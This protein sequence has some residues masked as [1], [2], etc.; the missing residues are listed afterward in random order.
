MSEYTEVERP[1]LQQLVELGWTV[2]DQGTGVPQDAAPSLRGNFR[3]WLLPEVFDNA[4]RTINRTDDGREWLTN[5]Q[6][7]DLRS[8]LLRHPNRTLLEA[9]EAVQAM[10]FKA[11][12]DVNE[13][14]GEADPVV[15]LIDFH[16]PE[17]NQFHAINQFRVDTPGCVKAFIIPDIVLFVNGIPLVVVECKKGSETCANPMQEAFVQ[18]QR[19][20]RRRKET[21]AS[22]LKE[23]EPQ[24]FYSSLM[25]VRS[26]GLEADYGTISS[27]EEHF[28]AWKTLHPADDADSTG[29]NAQQQLIAGMLNK[30]NLL[31][32][33]RTSSVFMDTDG[34]PRVKV[35]C[36]Y[37]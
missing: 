31:Q 26:C 13:L 12:A 24:L 5:R 7:E 33:L 29:L 32:I 14:T 16:S 34:G 4:V 11:Q 23:G 28:Y 21:E 30:A 2:I 3:Q 9:N 8:Q 27:S 37:Q 15:R 36:R 6:L 19:Y 35:V 25:L 1:F 17:N 10:L 18:L 22:G 20:M